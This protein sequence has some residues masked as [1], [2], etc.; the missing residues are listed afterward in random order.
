MRKFFKWL[1]IS[2]ASLIAL[3]FIFGGAEESSE[4]EA[5]LGEIDVIQA[6]RRAVEGML[7]FP[8]TV[9][10]PWV[11]D[12]TFE[13]ETG[14]IIKTHFTAKNRFGVDIGHQV[15][16]EGAIAGSKIEIVTL[17]VLES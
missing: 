17:E 15:H 11:P 4:T 13:T 1:T 3:V 8:D 6:C 2:F 5:A 12:R 9:D 14:Y 10:W 16:C 7:N